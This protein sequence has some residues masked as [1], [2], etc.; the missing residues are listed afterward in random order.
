M[1]NRLIFC[2]LFVTGSI[3]L[4]GAVAGSS[5][6]RD[7]AGGSRDLEKMRRDAALFFTACK[8][9]VRVILP[10]RG[11]DASAASG[12]GRSSELLVQKPR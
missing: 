2:A 5:D 3:L 7:R 12:G 10:S 6:R 1:Q 11:A 4:F 9:D 8:R